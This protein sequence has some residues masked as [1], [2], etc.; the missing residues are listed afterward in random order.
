MFLA[1]RDTF[2]FHPLNILGAV[3]LTE[4]RQK[5]SGALIRRYFYTCGDYVFESGIR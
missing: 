2:T 1:F 3:G 4:L 5:E